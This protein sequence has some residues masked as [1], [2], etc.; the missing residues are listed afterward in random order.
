[1]ERQI[2]L[3]KIKLTANPNGTVTISERHK[4]T[5][6]GWV[7]DIDPKP[8]PFISDGSSFPGLVKWLFTILSKIELFLIPG[9]IHDWL[10]NTGEV[11]EGLKK[12]RLTRKEADIIWLDVCTHC[13]VGWLARTLGYIGLRLGGW[14]A[15]NYYRKTDRIRKIQRQTEAE[16]SAERK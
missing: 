16:Q 13:G 1:M 6:N 4:I 11:W 5:Y 12:Y 3:P 8:T 2:Q 10:Y 15:W 9:G 7:I 14:R